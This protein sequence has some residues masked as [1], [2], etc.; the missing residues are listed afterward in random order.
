MLGPLSTG[1]QISRPQTLISSR[2]VFDDQKEIRRI[3]EALAFCRIESGN[4]V[5]GM[6]V[7]VDLCKINPDMRKIDSL[8]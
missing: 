4:P 5:A 2:L 7:E 1:G 6:P 3:L 8:T